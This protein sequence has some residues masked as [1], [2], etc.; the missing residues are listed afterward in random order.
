MFCEFV[1]FAN[2]IYIHKIF[3]K[4]ENKRENLINTMT[5]NLTGQLYDPILLIYVNPHSETCNANSSSS[6]TFNAVRRETTTQRHEE[7]GAEGKEEE[8]AERN[9]IADSTSHNILPC[10]IVLSAA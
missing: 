1:R 4:K 9:I 10:G 6:C 8:E 2:S 7:Q 5:I 3:S